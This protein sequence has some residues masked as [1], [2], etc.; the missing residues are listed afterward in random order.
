MCISF[1]KLCVV[2]DLAIGGIYFTVRK[3]FLNYTKF[4]FLSTRLSEE[5]SNLKG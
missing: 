3:P 5:A 1:N 2:Y 4:M